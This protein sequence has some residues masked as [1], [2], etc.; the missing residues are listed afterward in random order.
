MNN[1]K[2]EEDGCSS[3]AVLSLVNQTTW[4]RDGLVHS[5]NILT[6]WKLMIWH[7]TTGVCR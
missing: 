4:W 1:Q 2:P 3:T 5:L 7:V 6:K